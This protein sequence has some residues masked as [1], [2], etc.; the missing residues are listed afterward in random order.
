MKKDREPLSQFSF[1]LPEDAALVNLMRHFVAEASRIYEVKTGNP[2]TDALQIITP[3]DVYEFFRT[4]MED[5]QQ[6]QLRTIQLN[7]KQRI[8]SSRLLYQGT[9]NMTTIRV[10]E[11]FRQAIIDNAASIIICHN[12]PSGIPDASPEDVALTRELVKAGELLDLEIL[13]HVIIGK[14][15]FFSLKERGLGFNR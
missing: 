4:E 13:D 11:V 12:H 7:T 15:K 9:I 1:L 14:G 3:R 10:A 6:E 2:I 5:L 8:L